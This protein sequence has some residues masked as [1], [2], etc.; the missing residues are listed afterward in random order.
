MPAT[1]TELAPDAILERFDAYR[2]RFVDAE[3]EVSLDG[4]AMRAVAARVSDAVG[5]MIAP[6]G[7][8]ALVAVG[9]GPLFPAAIAA[10]LR[11]GVS[12]LMVHADTPEAELARVARQWRCALLVADGLGAE[13]GDGLI[14]AGAAGRLVVRATGF[15]AAPDPFPASPLHQT[16]GTSGTPKV[17]VRH[18]AAAVAEAENYARAMAIDD[19]DTVLCVSP[20]SHAYAYGMAFMVP[21]VTGADCVALRRFNPRMVRNLLA[22]DVASIAPLTPAMLPLLLQELRSTGDRLRLVLS[23]GAPLA[24]DLA[25][26]FRDA[27]GHAPRRL[28]GTTE[29]GGIAVA[30]EDDA[31]AGC[32]AAM[33]G[34]AVRI[35][36]A[37]L[38]AEHGRLLVR[39][40]SMMAGYL[41][42]NGIAPAVDAQGWYATGDLARLDEAGR[43]HLAGRTGEVVNVLGFKVL[44]L[45]VEEVLRELP[46]VADA[47]VYAGSHRGTEAVFAA[48]VPSDAI[49]ASFDPA[50]RLV[51]ELLV[52]PRPVPE[53]RALEVLGEACLEALVAGRVLRRENG[54]FAP[55]GLRLRV[56]PDAR[57]FAGDGGPRC[58]VHFGHDT[59]RFIEAIRQSPRRGPGLELCAGGSSPAIALA[60]HCGE[61]VGVEICEPVADVARLNVAL[62]GESARTTI[63]T[64]D[65]WSAVAG[66]RYGLIV[67]NPPFSPSEEDPFDDPAAVAGPDGLDVARAIWNGARDHLA[68]S[69][70]LLLLL[71]MLG[72][73][74]APQVLGELQSL[75]ARQRWRI[76]IIAL[77]APR[78]LDKLTIPRLQDEPIERRLGQIRGGAARIGA[79]HYH[80]ALLRFREGSGEVVLVDP[81]ETATDAFRQRV[82]EMRRRR[83]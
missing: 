60:R 51:F 83:T 62:N 67:S 63:R 68:P 13:P 61:A 1:L 8:R 81:N 2:G 14:D 77:D 38:S 28:L 69:G 72:D 75:A 54:S 40:S 25:R 71:G 46:G 29:T 48:I 76:E 18:A 26:R 5:A 20:M 64:G 24:A 33:E 53:G 11:V 43:I 52:S 6:A 32:G 74:R 57:V 34:V 82:L 70:E 16:S 66:E 58:Y 27:T 65:L 36:D 10:M 45:E 73:A 78:A 31:D 35:D 49:A 50:E 22:S 42:E 41:D 23:A 37:G 3:R 55:T 47:A 4:E 19:A 39:S 80:V 44:P 56:T 30:F 7:A 9:N 21:L 12:P 17:A 59:L 15:F 79:S